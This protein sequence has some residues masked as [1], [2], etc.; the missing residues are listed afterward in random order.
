[1]K[2]VFIKTRAKFVKGGK[3]NKIDYEALGIDPPEDNHEFAEYRFFLEDL[4]GYNIS[5]DDNLT[6][7]EFYSGD[8]ITIDVEFKVFDKIFTDNMNVIVINI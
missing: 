6:T 1:M 4:K 2:K 7:I 5:D 8:R 3:D